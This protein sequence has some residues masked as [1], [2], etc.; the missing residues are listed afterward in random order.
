MPIDSISKFDRESVVLRAAT[1]ADSEAGA[2]LIYMTGPRIFKYLY[3]P[4]MDRALAILKGFFEMEN[5]EFSY[6]DVT[7]AEFQSRICGLI[8]CVD[9]ADMRRNVRAMGRKMIRVMGLLP[10]L[11]RMPRSIQFE[12]IF[13][14]IGA[15]TL[16]IGHIAIFEDY[17]GQGIAGKLLSFSELMAGQR[18]LKK[19]A[20]DV[21][22]DN[23]PAFGVYEKYG[24]R[25]TEKIESSKFKARFGFPGTYRM[26]KTLT[27]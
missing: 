24:F 6:R 21:E 26:E 4:R 23:Q 22:L 27:P 7:V 15:H 13:P 2:R 9:R 20:L 5:N 12:S 8:H 25:I 1:P 10:A 14:R 19:L 16:Y 11:K 17:R 18:H 3:Y